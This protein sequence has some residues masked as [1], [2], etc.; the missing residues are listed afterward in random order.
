MEEGFFKTAG[1]LDKRFAMG[2]P[3]DLTRAVIL[4]SCQE[5]KK[6]P[7][8]LKASRRKEITKINLK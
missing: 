2:L 7:D 4:S 3:D 1:N 6:E 5:P 8:K